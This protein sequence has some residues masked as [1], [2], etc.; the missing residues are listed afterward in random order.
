M[1]KCL[2]KRTL[3]LHVWPYA[4]LTFSCE[5]REE[6]L[7]E[8]WA[9][10]PEVHPPAN[11]KDWWVQ[12][13]SDGRSLDKL[14]LGPPSQN[15]VRTFLSLIFA[16]LRNV[17]SFFCLFFGNFLGLLISDDWS[18]GILQ[19]QQ[20]VEVVQEPFLLS[21]QF[22][23]DFLCV[24]PSGTNTCSLKALTS[25]H[26]SPTGISTPCL[27]GSCNGHFEKLLT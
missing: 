12:F 26:I 15:C 21:V 14:W 2:D 18:V 19:R 6:I 16:S 4:L 11:S 8:G 1:V 22:S 27:N 23:W 25:V 9:Q 24:W 17:F 3:P 13:S 10:A 20:V 7:R 5:S